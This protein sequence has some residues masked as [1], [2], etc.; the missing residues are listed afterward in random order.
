[1]TSRK[2]DAST[3]LPSDLVRRHLRFG[4]WLLFASAA[5]GLAVETLNGFRV[6]WYVD[7][8]S[9]TRRHMLTL[10]H[11]H[12]T[13]LG[14][15][16]VVFALSLKSGLV[17]STRTNLAAACLMAASIMLPGGF[18]TGGL[19]VYAGDPGLGIIMVPVGAALFLLAVFLVAR[20]TH[21]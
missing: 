6:P 3:V 11:A 18:L 1:M 7:V 14:I 5:I 16:N 19:V 2:S 4:W 10:G 8:T 13:L 9:T 17:A 20:A 15:V 12:G 21:R